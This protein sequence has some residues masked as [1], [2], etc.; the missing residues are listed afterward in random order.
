[1]SSSPNPTANEQRTATNPGGFARYEHDLSGVPATAYLGVGYTERAPD[2]WELITNESPTTKSAFHTKSEKTTQLD[3]GLNFRRGAFTA[4][5]S[6]FYNRVGDY[7]LVQTNVPK[8]S[9]MGGMGGMAMSTA[10]V[11]R[12]IDA[13][14]LGGEAGLGCVIAQNWK[15]DAS[16]AYVQGRNKTDK[17][18]L[19]QQPPLE[20]RLGFAYTTP[21]WTV[22]ALIRGVAA[23]NRYALN[24][25]TIIGQDLGRTG[26]FTVFSLNAGWRVTQYALLTAGVDNVFDKTYAEHLSRN[27]GAVTGYPVT[28][29]VN[30]PGRTVWLKLALNY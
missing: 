29:R 5:I 28:M 15:V 9:G 26:G 6:A 13:S 4:S 20:A 21:V 30:E 24:Q 11:T 19:A 25:G 18:P 2:Y 17:L 12:N 1:M 27:G 22:G 7:I 3:T 10:T 23:Q 14:S 16:L 8:S